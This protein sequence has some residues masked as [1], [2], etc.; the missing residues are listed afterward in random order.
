MDNIWIN[1]S[2]SLEHTVSFKMLKCELWEECSYQQLIIDGVRLSNMRDVKRET[3]STEN[4][5][6]DDLLHDCL[7]DSQQLFNLNEIIPVVGDRI[8]FFKAYNSMCVSF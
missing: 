4:K 3:F 6:D 5:I 7:Q 8:R 1:L 2:V